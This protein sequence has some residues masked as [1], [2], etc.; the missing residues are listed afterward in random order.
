MSKESSNRPKSEAFAAIHSAASGLF[1]VGAIDR[2]EM[3]SFEKTCLTTRAEYLP[4]DVV[5]IRQSLKVSQSELAAYMNEDLHV[6]QQWEA[7]VLPVTG[8]AAKLLWLAERKGK[9]DLLD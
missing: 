6:V 8:T 2:A 9:L 5:R 7:G 3:N 1:K 4:D